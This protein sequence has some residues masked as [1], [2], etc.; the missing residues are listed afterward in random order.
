MNFMHVGTHKR[1]PTN[2]H[3]RTQPCT[4]THTH[5][6]PDPLDLEDSILGGI[7][8]AWKTSWDPHGH[9]FQSWR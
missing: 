7:C 8:T 9:L 2:T 1:S 6:L 3:T 5:T 4:R